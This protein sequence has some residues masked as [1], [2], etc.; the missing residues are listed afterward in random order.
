MKEIK[1]RIYE[2]I[3]R[4]F[5]LPNLP[6]NEEVLRE[7][8]VEGWDSLGHLNLLMELEKEFQIKFSVEDIEK[9]RSLR[10]LARLVREKLDEGKS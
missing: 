10:E 6:F 3:K 7:G 9:S 5:N 4:T 2:V 8:M 1:N